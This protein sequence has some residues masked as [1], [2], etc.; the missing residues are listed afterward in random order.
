[1]KD[2][3]SF[4]VCSDSNTN[5]SSD[6]TTETR[7][8]IYLLDID[9]NLYQFDP[10][11]YDISRIVEFNCTQSFIISMAVQRNGSLWLFVSDGNI[12]QYNLRTTE[13]Q[14]IVNASEQVLNDSESFHGTT[15]LK[16]AS[17]D[18]ELLYVMDYTYD[19]PAL[20]IFNRD[21]Y[22]FTVV[23]NISGA[24]SNIYD[25]A[26]TSTG[27]LFGM[28]YYGFFTKYTRLVEIDSNTGEVLHEY[29]LNTTSSTNNNA[30]VNY[31][32]VASYQNNFF[33][34]SELYSYHSS[35]YLF[36]PTKNVITQVRT[37]PN[38]IY[39]ATSSSCLGT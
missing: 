9:M 2:R 7:N 22:R 33:F 20:V 23:N 35:A 4:F 21:T 18:Q 38:Y 12:Y 14:L 16:S 15:F 32:T 29:E 8:S 27:R 6:C 17:S 11:N 19:N 28:T 3:R 25:L 13:C 30:T 31:N 36:N 1:M 10:I 5:P 37:L 34:F 24:D 39:K 26:G